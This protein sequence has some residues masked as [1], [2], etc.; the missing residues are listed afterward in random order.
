MEYE[1][2]IKKKY[3]LKNLEKEFE[4]IEKLGYIVAATEHSC[5]I[6]KRN[7]LIIDADFFDDYHTNAADAI[8]GFWE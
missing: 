2:K 3:P 7:V 8:E 5:Q 1:E 6:W 4:R